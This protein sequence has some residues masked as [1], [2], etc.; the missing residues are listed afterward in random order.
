MLYDRQAMV[1]TM[2]GVILFRLTSHTVSHRKEEGRG[3]LHVQIFMPS[4]LVPQTATVFQAANGEF[5]VCP[6]DQKA[7][8]FKKDKH[9]LYNYLDKEKMLPLETKS[10]GHIGLLVINYQEVLLAS[11]TLT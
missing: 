5:R 6:T 1:K 8:R 10:R 7:F 2:E 9:G 3:A 11:Q 4:E